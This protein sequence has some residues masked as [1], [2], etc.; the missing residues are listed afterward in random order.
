M[1]EASSI[2]L[3]HVVSEDGIRVGFRK[4]GAGPALVMIHGSLAEGE[5][6]LPLASALSEDFTVWVADSRGRG[7]SGDF[8]SNYGP[9]TITQDHQALVKE[10][11]GN[12][13]LFGHSFGA[14]S[15]LLSAPGLSDIAGVI[16]YEPPLPVNGMLAPEID[17]YEASVKA[18]NVDDAVARAFT[19]I[20]GGSTEELEYVKTTPVWEAMTS[21]APTFIPELRLLDGLPKM[22]EQVAKIQAPLLAIRGGLSPENLRESTAAVAEA[23]PAGTLLDM[24][25]IDHSGHL[26][27]PTGMAKHIVQW[28]RETVSS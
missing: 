23:A 1:S 5:E 13:V 3:G 17:V 2:E 10:A 19:N 22:P 26:S 4:L 25:H 9:G 24:A 6:Y 15:V 18:G 27:D 16:A 7:L 21:I 8:P 28:F 12:V 14:T 20:V 11:G